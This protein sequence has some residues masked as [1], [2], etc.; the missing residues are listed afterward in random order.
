MDGS[1]KHRSAQAQRYEDAQVWSA[2]ELVA[3]FGSKTKL[4]EQ[5]R[6]EEIRPL[7]EGFYSANHLNDF[8]AKV[9]YVAKYYE[10]SVL[11]GFTALRL[12]RLLDEEVNWVEVDTDNRW[13]KSNSLAQ[14]HW[15]KPGQLI[16]ATHLQVYQ[17]GV[18]VYDVERALV[19]A[20]QSLAHKDFL[21]QA[22]SR[23]LATRPINLSQIKYYDERLG[24]QVLKVIEQ[25]KESH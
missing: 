15:V 18:M 23:Y 16:G 24:T 4:E 2:D 9:S 3:Q 17:T 25:I 1:L 5:L 10:K 8:C 22:I 19:S 13:L 11:C 7:G 20:Y 6:T 12:H 14:F 21:E